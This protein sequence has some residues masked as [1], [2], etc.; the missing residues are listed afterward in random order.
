MYMFQSKEEVS[1]IKNQGKEFFY[2]FIGM[3]GFEPATFWS[4]TR[5]ATKLRYIPDSAGI[6]PKK[7]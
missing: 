5:H 4:Q 6:I 1:K 3:A 7:K 2:G